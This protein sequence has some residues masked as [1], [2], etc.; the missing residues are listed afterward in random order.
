[1]SN[2]DV[3]D[4]GI[5]LELEQLDAGGSG[6]F[7]AQIIGVFEEQAVELLQQLEDSVRDEQVAQ[8]SALSHKLKG[9]ARTVGGLRLGIHCE[10]LEQAAR[11]QEIVDGAT[12][13]SRIRNA[14]AELVVALHARLERP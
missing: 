4:E 14:Y 13:I 5:I 1:V 3:L 11:S 12:Q 8:I 6:G 2:E 9:S 10:H 7:L